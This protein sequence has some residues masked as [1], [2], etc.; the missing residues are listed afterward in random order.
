MTPAPARQIVALPARRAPIASRQPSRAGLL[1]V[2]PMTAALAA[3]TLGPT[4]AAGTVTLG[5]GDKLKGSIVTHNED[6]L[7]LQHKT[8]GQ[9]TL[10]QRQVKSV[11]YSHTDP[12][13][14]GNALDE[15][16]LPGW[17]KSLEVG[18]S[19]TDGNT[20]TLN[21]YAAFS[22]QQET[23]RDR[24]DIQAR[25]FLAYDEGD[26]TRDEGHAFVIKD[27]LVPDERY[28]YFATARVDHDGFSGYDNRYSGFAGV[29]YDFVDDDKWSVTGRL[30]AGGNYEAGDV[31]EFTP[32]ALVGVEA[33]WKIDE[34]QRFHI[35]STF[36]PA[37]DPL[38]GEF[39]NVSGAEYK[40]K[41]AAGRGLSLKLG[42]ENEYLSEV[43]SG[44][45][46]NDL[47]YFGALVYDF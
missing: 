34:E 43:E 13:Y 3:A 28:F 23:E 44:T 5:N 27:W 35:Y 37:L 12:A 16:F 8:L 41:L 47:N 39:R 33:T 46:H 17:D 2:A 6:G 9:L 11:A 18:F 40:V 20:E 25:Y 26:Q 19:G 45:E 4:V 29:G 10:E 21:F 24:W 7:Y 22:T 42:I 32:E 1:R 31:N 36:F 14:E 30:G 38:F 15:W